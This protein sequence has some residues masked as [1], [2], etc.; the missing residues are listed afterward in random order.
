M[1]TNEKT[2]CESMLHANRRIPF[3]HNPK[4]GWWRDHDHMIG[5]HGTHA[6][7]VDTIM[8]NGIDRPDPKTGMISITHD[9]HTAHG[10]AAMSASGGEAHFRDARTGSG[11]PNAVHTP[12]EHRAVVKMR[13]PMKWVHDNMDHTLRGNI[14]HVRDRMADK[15]HY[16]A[17]RK[18]NPGKG[19]HEYY[20]TSEIRIRKHIPP[21]YIVGY[22]KRKD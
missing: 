13:L 18:A 12:H 16:D 14:G 7:N 8:Q 22:M 6:R 17:W 10:Y 19:D 21:E 11:A 20:A 2:H 3:E 1:I 5:Y 4:I 9:P 15:N